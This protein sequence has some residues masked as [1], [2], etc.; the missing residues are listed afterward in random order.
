L[1][2]HR[3]VLKHRYS[4]V[5]KWANDIKKSEGGLD[6]F[7]KVGM[8]PSAPNQL[9]RANNRHSFQ[10]YETFG[11]NAQPNG[12]IKYREWAPNAVEASLV[13]DFSMYILVEGKVKDHE[14]K[15]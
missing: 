8:N 1:E 3:D 11:L 4:L 13:G 2:P 14:P 5:E 7:S 15:Y 6:K 9:A 10:G 12:D